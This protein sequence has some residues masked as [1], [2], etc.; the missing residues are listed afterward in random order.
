MPKNT[1][2]KTAL[3]KI[4]LAFGLLVII[5]LAYLALDTARLFHVLETKGP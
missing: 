5:G 4:G 1:N 3:K 2:R